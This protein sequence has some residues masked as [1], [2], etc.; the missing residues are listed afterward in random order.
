VA[1]FWQGRVVRGFHYRISSP[2]PISLLP[3]NWH[4]PHQHCA[5]GGRAARAKDFRVVRSERCVKEAFQ[6][7]P[8]R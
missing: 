5:R 8:D 6:T 3:C 1:A 2:Q 7:P 4:S